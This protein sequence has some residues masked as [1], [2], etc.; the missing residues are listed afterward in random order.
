MLSVTSLLS[1]CT[2]DM[3]GRLKLMKK[4]ERRCHTMQQPVPSAL[5]MGQVNDH[6][7]ISTNITIINLITRDILCVLYSQVHFKWDGCPH[8]LKRACEG[9]KKYPL[10]T[11]NGTVGHNK[12]IYNSTRFFYGTTNDLTTTRW[13]AFLQSIR[14]GRYGQYQYYLYG[15]NGQPYIC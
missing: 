3:L 15:I 2:Q 13:D 11:F 4:L 14:N 7:I 12:K 10:L 9:S 6:T 8:E 5:L 1:K